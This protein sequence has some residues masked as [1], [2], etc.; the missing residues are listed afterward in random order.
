MT[1]FPHEVQIRRPHQS[2]GIA[3]HDPEALTCQ[4][5]PAKPGTVAFNP[6]G[7]ELSSPQLLMWSVDFPL[8][9]PVGSVFDFM[10]Q[11]YVVQTPTET[12]VAHRIAA[13][14][15]CHCEAMQFTP[16]TLGVLAADGFQSASSGLSATSGQGV[17]HGGTGGG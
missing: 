15:S 3:Y 10:G 5:T 17:G 4:F 11:W 6:E 14:C 7:V 8:A 1:Y 9:C 13:S 16:E 12:F 2:K